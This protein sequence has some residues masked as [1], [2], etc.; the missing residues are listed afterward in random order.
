MYILEAV[1]D[2]EATLRA[3]STPATRVY[4]AH[5]R[6]CTA[7]DAFLALCRK[8]W[9]CHKVTDDELHEVFQAEDVTV[10]LL[11][12]RPKVQAATKTGTAVV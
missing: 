11:Q 4:V 7:E 12:L 9:K 5:G 2:L 3:L 6:N 8:R 1:E 10:W